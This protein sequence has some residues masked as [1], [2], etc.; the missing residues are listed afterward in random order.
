MKL[1]SDHKLN[2]QGFTIIELMIATII[3]SV[4]LVFVST[5]MIGIGR[6][7][8]KGINQNRVQDNARAINDEVSQ[9]LQF[10]GSDVIPVGPTASGLRRYCIGNVRYTYVLNKRIGPADANHALHVLWRDTNPN[11]DTCFLLDTFFNTTTPSAGG[12]ELIAA[13]SRLTEFTITPSTSPYTVRVGVLF[14]EGADRP[15]DSMIT[16]SGIDTRCRGGAGSQFCATGT[17]VST[18]AR[19]SIN[20]N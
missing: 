6:I 11:P 18:V 8:Y 15:T 14:G 20:S 1:I 7:Y 3:V 16:G 17:S 9:Q 12:V 13:N 19:R 2:R 4:I 5:V 10:N